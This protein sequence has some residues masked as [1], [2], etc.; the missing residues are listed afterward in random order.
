MQMFFIRSRFKCR[1]I[2]FDGFKLISLLTKVLFYGS[3]K[4]SPKTSG[5]TSHIVLLIGLGLLLIAQLL[6]LLRLSKKL[7]CRCPTSW[8]INKPKPHLLFLQ[9][10]L[11]WRFFYDI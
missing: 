3:F 11:K 10:K 9:S 2:D 6:M 7:V 1:N 8:P 4:M 5:L